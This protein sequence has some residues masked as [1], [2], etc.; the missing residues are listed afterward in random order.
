MNYEKELKLS[1]IFLFEIF[2]IDNNNIN[3]LGLAI[4]SRYIQLL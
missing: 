2:I 3:K 4:T 1:H